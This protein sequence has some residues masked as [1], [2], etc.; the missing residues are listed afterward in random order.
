MNS[1][2]RFTKVKIT[3]GYLLL[4][5]VLFSSLFLVHREIEN[6]SVL[7][8][9]QV[10]KSDSLLILLR[11]K[12]EN[13]I[14]MLRALSE[15]NDKLLSMDVLEE[16]IAGQDSV[17]TQQRVQHRVITTR[18][19]IITEA[20]KKGFFK[21]LGEVFSP[22][23]DT[24]TLVNT[25]LELITDTLLSEY[26]PVDSIHQRILAA[27]QQKKES[28][29]SAVQRN[30][31]RLRR[32]NNMLTARIDSLVKHYEKEIILR[33]RQEAENQQNIRL[34]STRIIG[35]IAIGAVLLSAVFLIIIWRDITRSNRYRKE[36]EE[37][38]KRAEELLQVREKLMLTITHD[39]KA[40]L[41]SIIGYTDLLSRLVDD[42]RQKFYLDNM[43][44]SSEHL[45]K[46]VNDLLD[47]HRLDL[48]KEEI[49]R[50]SFDPAKL[51]DEIRVSFDPLVSG[52][53]LA[54]N[55][56]IYPELNG[57]FVSD[58]LRI[59]QVVTNLLSNAVKFTVQ[60]S[61]TLLVRYHAS[62]LIIRV[63]DTGKGMGEGD[64]ERIF[65]EFT[66]LPGAQGEEGFGLGLSI[67]RKLVQLLEGT[68]SVESKE[69]K[70]SAFTVHI[71][72]YPVLE[73]AGAEL[74]APEVI[75]STTSP[76]QNIL[77]IDDDKIQLALTVAMLES[78]G[79]KAT[80]CEQIEALTEYLR[81]E[82]FDILLTDVQMP[83]INGFDL[84]KLLRASNIPQAKTIPIIAVTA[85]GDIHEAEFL[86]HGFAG[87]LKKPFS[88]TD[89][90]NVLGVKDA[91]KGK[92]EDKPTSSAL[93]FK[94]LTTFS[95]DDKDA[96]QAIIETFIQETEKNAALL[97]KA[98]AAGNVAGIAALAHKLLPLFTLIG[99]TEI[100]PSL[101][102]LESSADKSFSPK[103]LEETEKVLGYV[104]IVLREA[105]EEIK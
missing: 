36:L 87:C 63:S 82:T 20:P 70:G 49:N 34:R 32:M 38:R 13:T 68:I 67:V 39:F 26:N 45:L 97:Q 48:N 100:T 88:V 43:Q 65:Q 1:P 51:F 84:L 61:V 44:S 53:G 101:L 37:A 41:G 28:Q 105:R 96:A 80:G 6:L 8:T 59:R 23:K 52:K 95:M 4:L 98:L 17:I 90:L 14:H 42:D 27:S 56:E 76:A 93:N 94:S 102:W 30:N 78:Q 2:S 57:R 15:A 19:S 33:A 71:P 75:A 92:D 81:K 104:E 21:R 18:D 35:G 60:G 83:A 55:Y 29:Q 91:G 54:L 3:A 11:E 99:A 9:E 58:P 64:K 103:V 7:D 62:T 73:N 31:A 74:P 89:L 12:D 86:S 25:T 40:P 50:I 22:P 77:L 72:L 85:R 5:L 10:L 66:R 47:F 16:I 79:F 24:A 69:G 46:L